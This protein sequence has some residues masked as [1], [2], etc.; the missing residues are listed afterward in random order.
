MKIYSRKAFDTINSGYIL[1][2]LHKIGIP[3]GMINWIKTCITTPYFSINI[4]GEL[5]GWFKSMKGFNRGIHYPYIF[6]L[7]MERL[8]G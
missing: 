4:N 8:N 3:I 7:V 6:V 1:E 2:G 5:Q